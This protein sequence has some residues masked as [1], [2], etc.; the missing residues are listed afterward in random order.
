MDRDGF[1]SNGELFLV[2]K[3]M[4]GNNLKDS[5][6]QQIVDKTIM[7]ADKDGDGKLSFD[8]FVQMVSNTVR[9]ACL[10]PTDLGLIGDFAGYRQAN[11]TGGSVLSISAQRS[12]LLL[13][14]YR[15]RTVLVHILYSTIAYPAHH[16]SIL[17][18]SYFTA[19]YSLTL[20]QAQCIL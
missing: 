14:F 12:S 7:E 20:P 17:P 1:I 9:L 2:L 3:M 8:E 13:L 5:Q 19:S 10:C 11:D 4:V 6:L 18:S 15:T 16:P